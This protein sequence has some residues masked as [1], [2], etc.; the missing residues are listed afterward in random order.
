[1]EKILDVRNLKVSFITNNGMVKAV[2]DI[3]FSLNKGETLAIVGESGSGKSVTARAAMGI[4]AGN[5]VTESGEIFFDGHDLTKISEETF[6]K[7]RGNQISMIFQDPFSSLSPIVRIGKQLTEAMLL[8][9]KLDRRAARRDFN[10]RLKHINPH[11]ANPAGTKKAFDEYSK[12]EKAYNAAHENI[13]V[14]L[15]AIDGVLIDLV[16]GEPKAIVRD[17]NVIIKNAEKCYHKHLVSRDILPELLNQLKGECAAYLAS[18]NNTKVKTLLGEVR[19]ILATAQEKPRYDFFADT[20]KANLKEDYDTFIASIAKAA[21]ASAERSIEGK[22]IVVSTIDD[23]LPL[24]DN[25]KAS[26]AD[27][28]RAVADMKKVMAA[29][30]D[31]L[32]ISKDNL[33]YSFGYGC[34][35]A[36]KAY[37]LMRKKSR[38]DPEGNAVLLEDSRNNVRNILVRSK[39]AY[40][41]ELDDT[42]EKDYTDIAHRLVELVKSDSAR[43]VLYIS[44]SLA[45][46]RAI[47]LMEEV[48][49]P[50]AR[51]RYRQYPFQFSGGMRQRIVIA[52]ALA[53]N[54]DLLICDEPTTA[55]DVTI[56]AQIL[57]LIN[58]LKEQ[59]GLSVI[60]ITHDLGVVANVAD[61]IA[62]MYAGKIVEYGTVNEVFYEPAHPYTWALLSSMPDL[63]TTEKIEA[64]P[65][66]PPN[67]I[68]PPVGDAF[69]ARNKYALEIDFEEEPPFF[70]ISPTHKAATWLLHPNAPKAEP[71]QI[72]TERIKRMRMMEDE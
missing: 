39:D 16:R 27:C 59:R 63:E 65:G 4:S 60:F 7:I 37:L 32:A 29:S 21:K 43:M 70:D 30:I 58:N 62:V 26:P 54:P 71:P 24:F 46:S 68:H 47:S 18:G 72:I 2:R 49:I 55:L 3:S 10:R 45:K 66:T 53:A 36:L 44:K 1:M 6:Q 40:Q 25:D 17:V 67:M 12:L 51:A 28:K 34:D 56:Q 5:S 33:A 9:S 15:T 61:H 35:A 13:T 41:E 14:Q 20:Y 64:I 52:I 69:A 23:K 19:E 22:K 57:D 42:R 11:L 38:K 50:E 31:S 48:G 8:N